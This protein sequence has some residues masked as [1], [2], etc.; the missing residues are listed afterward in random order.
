MARVVVDTD[1]GID[2]ALALLFLAARPDVELVAVG[3]TH[4]NCRT[5]QAT[6]N[7]LRVLEACGLD[8]VPVAE[9]LA[10][11]LAQ[12]L[13]VAAHVHGAD[14]L[15]ETYLPEPRGR[16]TGEAAPAQLLRLAHEHPGELDLLALGPLTNLGAA[17]RE[18]PQLLTRFRRVVV[19]GGA[20]L[21]LAPDEPDRWRSIGDPNTY[22]DAEAAELVYGAPGPVELVPVALT[23]P[24][25][26][27][28]DGLARLAAAPTPQ[29]QLA[30]KV[31]RFYVDFYAT[32][33]ERRVCSLHDPLA[34]AVLADPSLVT[35]AAEGPVVLR[36][37][38]DGRARAWTLRQPVPGRPVHRVVQAVEE[39]RFVDELLD[40][41]TRPS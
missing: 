11:P 8:D 6:A 22:H 9:G 13:E 27:D 40:A 14:G 37:N 1:T 16:P 26:L 25:L 4:G 32:L 29:A 36:P 20:G 28:E 2:D 21:E 31:L 5:D 19:M 35:A 12:E 24:V 33:M 18:D 3:T 17:L 10:E 34:A 38:V 39:A 41:L 7:A 30:T 23:A 15:G